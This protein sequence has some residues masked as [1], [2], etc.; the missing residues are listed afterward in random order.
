MILAIDEGVSNIGIHGTQM[1][2]T[3]AN[4]I[5]YQ[6]NKSACSES[7]ESGNINLTYP[8]V[9]NWNAFYG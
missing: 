2:R 5:N 9:S 1:T 8:Q 4:I 3:S 7:S 6:L